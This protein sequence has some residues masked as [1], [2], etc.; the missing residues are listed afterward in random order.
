MSTTSIYYRSALDARAAGEL[1]QYRASNAENRRT[2]DV[3]DVVIS[4]HFD[5]MHLDRETVKNVLFNADADRVAL[6][7]AATMDERA[8]DGRF[9]AANRTWAAGIRRPDGETDAITGG[10]CWYTCRTH[11][12]I[13]NGFIS[14]FRR[15]LEEVSACGT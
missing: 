14:Q 1:D 4:E 5:G 7:L 2:R 13:L 15:H 8:H 9:S 12:S 11:S 10:R 3:I 6:V